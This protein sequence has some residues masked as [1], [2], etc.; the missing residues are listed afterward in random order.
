MFNSNAA[1]TDLE[2]HFEVREEGTEIRIT[3]DDLHVL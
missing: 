2:L 3:I 1:R